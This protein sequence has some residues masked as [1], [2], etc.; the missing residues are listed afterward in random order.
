MYVSGEKLTFLPVPCFL[1]L[2]RQI[3][4]SYYAAVSYL[5]TQ[6]GRLLSALDDVGLSNSTIVV[7]TGDHGKHLN[8]QLSNLV[9]QLSAGVLIKCVCFCNVQQSYHTLCIWLVCV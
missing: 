8:L 7:F 9:V 4:Q 1:N 5:D 6:V 3:R 2:Q